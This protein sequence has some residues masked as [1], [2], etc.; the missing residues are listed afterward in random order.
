LTVSTPA[1]DAPPATSATPVAS[2]RRAEPAR[3]AR[4]W[5]ADAAPW[6]LGA[7]V[8]WVAWLVVREALAGQFESASPSYALLVQPSDVTGLNAAGQRLVEGSPANAVALAQRSLEARPLNPEALRV[9]GEAKSAEGDN[10]S[11]LRLFLA[12]A[13]W[14]KRDGVTEAWLYDEHLNLRDY[15]A[16]VEDADR[17]M[18]VVPETAP[19]FYPSL[20]A[21]AGDRTARA[22]LIA[23]LD[24]APP[25]RTAFLWEL[26]RK[27]SDP[28][29]AAN[30]MMGMAAGGGAPTSDEAA[31]LL[32]RLVDT[33]RYLEAFLAWRQFAPDTATALTSVRDGDFQGLQAPPPFVWMLA[34]GEGASADISQAPSPLNAGSLSLHVTYDGASPSSIVASQLLV[35]APGDYRFAAKAFAPGVVNE[36]RLSWRLTCADTGQVLF[37][38]DPQGGV[39]AGWN[40]LGASAAVPATGC[41]GQWLRLV[42][43]PGERPTDVEVWFDRVAMTRATA[44]ADAQTAPTEKFARGARTN[45]GAG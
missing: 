21:M 9:L 44:Q 45:R 20:I 10:A 11:A 37:A 41:Q 36:T 19:A 23:R 27:G 25:W 13:R 38:T 12:A 35:L 15:P 39:D 7:L 16:A 28:M 5:A 31:P 1:G 26:S 22:P 42:T 43:Q 3:R 32:T 17:L 40:D 34:P 6:V 29:T 18:R 24:Q 30:L 2:A 33:Q 14:S 8:I 4:R